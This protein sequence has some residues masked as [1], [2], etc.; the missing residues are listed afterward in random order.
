MVALHVLTILADA[1]GA[2][3]GHAGQTCR[4]HA[5][6]TG[7]GCCHS[8]GQSELLQS[9]KSKIPPHRAPSPAMRAEVSQTMKEVRNFQEQS[10]NFHK[11]QQNLGWQEYLH[12]ESKHS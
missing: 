7:R 8:E 12:H 10:A 1:G 9:G 4:R 2:A 6:I 11:E 3:Q 5:G